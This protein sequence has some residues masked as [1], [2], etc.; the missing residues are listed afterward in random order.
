MKVSK[1]IDDYASDGPAHEK[2][3]AP[4]DWSGPV[5]KRSCTD[6][7]C[8]LLIVASWAAM[9][10]I[11]VYAIDKGDYRLVLYP[12]DYDGNVCGVNYGDRDMTEY[13]YLFYTNFVSGVCVKECPSLQGQTQDN[14]TDVNTLIT[15]TGVWQSEWGPEVSAD[16]VQMAD[17]SYT[18]EESSSGSLLDSITT[19]DVNNFQ[20]TTDLCFPTDS[21]KQSW[22][23]TGISEGYGFA[24]YLTDTYPLLG[25]CFLTSEARSRLA[26]LTGTAS[27]QEESIATESS[28]LQ[29]ASDFISNLYGDLWTS[30]Y[31][32]LMFGFG[33]SL[34]VSLTY[35]FLLRIPCL[36]SLLVWLSILALIGVFGIGGY[37]ALTLVDEWEAA[38]PPVVRDDQIT[39]TKYGSYACFVIAG[40]MFLLACCLRKQIQLAVQC[41]K[42]AGKAINNMLL[43]LLLPV[44][45]GVC[46]LLFVIAWA[47]YGSY[48][49]SLGEITITQM[50][51]PFSNYEIPVRTYE[52]S[53]LVTQLGWC[54][55]FCFFWTGSFI[56]AVGEMSI[57]MS[58]A[59]WYFT[60]DRNILTLFTP[61]SA[62]GSVIRYHLGTCA[63]GSLIIAIIKL[64]RALL[65]AFKKR[66][67]ELS[68][69]K[70]AKF[71]LCC[72]R[73]CLCCMEQCV[74]FLNENA[75]IQCAIFGTSFCESGRK[76][77]YLILRNAARIGAVSYVSAAVLIV[78]KLFISA[79]TTFAGYY[80]LTEHLELDLY[81]YAGP[82]T[83]IFIISYFVSD[84]FMDVFDYSILAILHC[85]VADEEMFD[86]RARYADGGL[87]DFV[88]KHG[89]GFDA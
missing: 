39:V 35:M 69:E 83:V 75:Y 34:V 61:F 38:D 30:K 28:D 2:L 19:V 81:S 13:P 40:L 7:L 86:G 50:E 73:C 74:Q 85:F 25:R 89:G 23:S 20:C 80:A 36:L 16:F 15:Y 42:Q 67:S 49:A 43:I 11:G 18:L 5:E 10:A 56:L 17:Y 1:T 8:L 45:Q 44:I 22:V 59:K 48:L 53:D 33:L 87:N 57:S 63:F 29:S 84:M 76:A 88:D 55:I 82:V 71:L 65:E 4:P 62:L 3:R 79:L 52:Y 27:N 77:F 32:I 46:F 58:I 51:V 41:V 31:Y 70:L 78:G 26:E 37:Y 60:T 9:T 54:L 64:L 24:Y 66:L 68:N 47:I 6:L 72:C 14:L 21:V 12:L